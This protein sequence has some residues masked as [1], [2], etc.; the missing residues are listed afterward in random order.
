M[1]MFC[2][3]TENYIVF[4]WPRKLL[5]VFSSIPCLERVKKMKEWGSVTCFPNLMFPKSN[6]TSKTICVMGI[7]MF[8]LNLFMEVAISKSMERFLFGKPCAL[9]VKPLREKQ[10]QRCMESQIKLRET[11]QMLYWKW[12]CRSAYSDLT[13]KVLMTAWNTKWTISV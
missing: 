3:C 4:P 5:N 8:L 2:F 1:Q 9:R 13:W 7:G 12:G 10:L 11:K 6:K